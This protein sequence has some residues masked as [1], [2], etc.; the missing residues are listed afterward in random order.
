MVNHDRPRRKRGTIAEI[1]AEFRGLYARVARKAG[2]DP[3]SVSR[4]ARGER[5]SPAIDEMLR[6]ELKRIVKD[7][8]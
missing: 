7:F 1:H 2:V 8:L 6:S 3:S 4:V 5:K